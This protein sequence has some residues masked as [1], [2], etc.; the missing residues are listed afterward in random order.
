MLRLWDP[1]G[2]SWY[3][4]LQAKATKRFSHGLDFASSFT[5]SKQQ[6]IGAESDVSFSSPSS[7]AS[8][9]ILN[10]GQNKYLSAYDQP[11]LF[12]FSGNYTLPKIGR[13]KALSW[14]VRD[15]QIGSVLRYGSGLP[16]MAPRATNGLSQ[17][18]FL[19]EGPGGFSGG[20]Y[21]NRVPGVPLFIHNPNCHCFDPNSTFELNPAAWTNPSAGTWGTSAAYYNDYRYQRHPVENMSLARNFR[22]RE[23]YNLQIRAEFTNIF[24]RT[25]LNN[26]SSTNAG[27]TQLTGPTGQTLSGFG[28]ISPT[29]TAA[30]PLPRQGTLVARFTF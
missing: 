4:A 2:D 6:T 30:T 10:R 9:D 21:A 19:S 11:F 18:L 17:L 20:T 7:P 12:V 26:P 24:N 15:W 29:Q 14:A 16:I 5:W 22:I 25:G 27:A 13:N 3:N 8:N 23:R 1:V 28:Y